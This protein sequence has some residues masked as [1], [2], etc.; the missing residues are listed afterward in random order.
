MK[1]MADGIPTYFR[2]T[3]LQEGYTWKDFEL[4]DFDFEYA[5]DVLGIPEESLES[6][7]YTDKEQLEI[8]LVHDKAVVSEDW[9]YALCCEAEEY[10]ASV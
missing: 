6:V 7:E 2:V 1:S 3:R 10:A 5:A 9:Y 4:S 8:I